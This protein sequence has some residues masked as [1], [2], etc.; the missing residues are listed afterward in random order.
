MSPYHEYVIYIT[1]SNFWFFGYFSESLFL[2]MLHEDVYNYKR[3]K[4]AHC[5]SWSLFN[6]CY[7]KNKWLL[8]SISEKRSEET[9]CEVFIMFNVSFIETCVKRNST[10]K[11]INR[12]VGR[13]WIF[14]IF[15]MK[16]S[17]NI[18]T[19]RMDLDEKNLRNVI[20]LLYYL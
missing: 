9:S 1:E 5:C 3:N 17:R 6:G 10:L 8:S 15:C 20:K 13:S 11:L 19:P 18:D 4:R 7:R 16:S 12:S 2:K 14:W